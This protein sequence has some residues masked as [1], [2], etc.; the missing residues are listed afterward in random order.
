MAISVF[1]PRGTGISIRKGG[2]KRI[3]GDLTV[4]DNV[5]L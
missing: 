5:T 3:F 1:T 2:S 4:P